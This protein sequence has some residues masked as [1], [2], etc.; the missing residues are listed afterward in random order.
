VHNGT[1]FPEDVT[2]RPPGE[3]ADD[4]LFL[5]G[6]KPFKGA[7]DVLD[8]WPN[9]V[10]RGF[11]GMLHWYGR[12]APD[13]QETIQSL[14]RSE[15]ISVHG[16]V[17]RSVLFDRAAASKVILVP[18][19]VEPFGMV[20]VEGMG[21]CAVPVAWDI[22]TGTREIVISGEDGLLVSLGDADAFAEAVLNVLDRYD[23]LAEQAIS[24]ARENFSEADMWD[25]YAQFLSD[26]A[27]RSPVQRKKAG[28][29]PPP[30]QP[31]TRYFQ[32]LP[33]ALRD[34]IRSVLSQSPRLS[35]WLRDWR[36]F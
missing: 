24:T 8:L 35:Y 15:R 20:T 11:T 21:M 23:A 29:S 31:P 27:D 26:L 9:L 28:G 19:R 25:R 4:L 30:Y 5:G 34:S 2:L 18:S 22:D 13:F 33:A 32:L 7:N 14:P 3:R 1:V 36:G 10:E 16:R 6:D 12:V 17:P